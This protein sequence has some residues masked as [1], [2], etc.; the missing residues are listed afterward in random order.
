MP[1]DLTRL[2][3]DPG[4]LA[5]WLDAQESEVGLEA[6]RPLSVRQEDVALR[7]HAVECRVNAEDP[8]EGFAPRFGTIAAYLPPGGPGIRVDSHLYSGYSVPIHYDSLLAKVI[9]WAPDRET[10][11]ERLVTISDQPAAIS[12][13]H[14]ADG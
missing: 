9:A 4:R 3:C 5:P 6:G 10:A 13:Q 12:R 8:D 7:G 14:M 11:I 2:L 1:D